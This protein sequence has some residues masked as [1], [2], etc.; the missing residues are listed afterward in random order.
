LEKR[1]GQGGEKEGECEHE[2]LYAM[3]TTAAVTDNAMRVSLLRIAEKHG[4]CGKDDH[5]RDW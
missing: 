1:A 5:P 3:I 2:A 4:V